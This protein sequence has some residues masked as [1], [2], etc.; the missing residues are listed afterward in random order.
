MTGISRN[1]QNWE[2]KNPIDICRENRVRETTKI[3]DIL[4]PSGDSKRAETN[5]RDLFERTG[6]E[7]GIYSLY[8]RHG[9]LVENSRCFSVED[10]AE[11]NWADYVRGFNGCF[12]MQGKL[13]P[14]KNLPKI[15]TDMMQPI[16][17]VD[18]CITLKQ[19]EYYKF[20]ASDGSGWAMTVNQYGRIYLSRTETEYATEHGTKEVCI[21]ASKYSYMLSTFRTCSKEYGAHDITEDDI[22]ALLEELGVKKGFFTVNIGSESRTYLYSN[23][24]RVHTQFEYDGRYYAYTDSSVRLSHFDVGDEWIIAGKKYAL[25]EEGRLAIPYGEDIFDVNYAPP[26]KYK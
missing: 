19:G 21:E 12:E 14:F 17:A 13:Y 23:D 25:D 26:M 7:E 8:S 6:E 18:N 10:I 3:L 20:T 4:M 2:R 5:R 11:I 15:P 1:D 24:G 16:R 22:T 9:Q